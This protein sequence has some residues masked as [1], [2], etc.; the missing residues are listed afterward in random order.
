MF[1]YIIWLNNYIYIFWW[2]LLEFFNCCVVIMSFMLLFCM[3]VGGVE[4][5]F[6]VDVGFYDGY[7]RR[8]EE[9]IVKQVERGEGFCGKGGGDFG[10]QGGDFGGWDRVFVDGVVV[11]FGVQ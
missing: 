11:F 10:F 6:D 8:V 4:E 3:F 7:G 9:E 5:Q 2:I 1:F